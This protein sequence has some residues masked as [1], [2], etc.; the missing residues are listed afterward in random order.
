MAEPDQDDK[1]NFIYPRSR[2]YGQFEPKNLIFN[3]NLQEFAQ[4]VGY[5]SNLETSGKLTPQQAYKQIK[6]LWKQLKRSKKE[7]SIGNKVE[8]PS[9]P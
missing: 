9:I 5:I 4:K 3:A 7:L 6:T 1:K 8:P 2:Y